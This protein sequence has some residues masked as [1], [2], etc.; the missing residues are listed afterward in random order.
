MTSPVSTT[1]IET[2]WRPLTEAEAIV[3]ATLLDDAW[4]LLLRRDSSIDTRWTDD[5]LDHQLVAQV[6]A[7]MVIRVM[8]NPDQHRSRQ[9]TVGPFGQSF[10]LS[11]GD[12]ENRLIVTVE[13][14]E[15]L[16]APAAAGGA[17]SIDL[18]L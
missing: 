17:F 18:S 16:A 12:D 15:M 7:A 11:Q 5:T 9:E 3:A 6:L 14:L 13:E 2:R 1:A 10:T 8:R 4:S